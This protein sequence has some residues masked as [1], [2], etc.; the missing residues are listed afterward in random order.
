MT[1]SITDASRIGLNSPLNDP[2]GEPSDLIKNFECGSAPNGFRHSDHVRLAFEYVTHYPFMEAIERFSGALKR[3]A[4][5]QG[6]P[7][8][9]HETITW[10]YLILIRERYE[11]AG[12]TQ[13]WDEFARNNADLL[14]WKG[15]LLDR[16][17]SK[18]SIESELARKVF[19]FPDRLDSSDG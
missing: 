4:A 18:E 8:L 14:I 3:F 11:R 16:F 13:K 12:G 5:D 10:A 7:Q 19:I 15:S 2:R 1:A 6:K 17:Y 9:Y